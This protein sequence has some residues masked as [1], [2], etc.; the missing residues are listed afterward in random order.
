MVG[1]AGAALREDTR[2]S[3]SRGSVLQALLLLKGCAVIHSLPG[4]AA[5]GRKSALSGHM[6][7]M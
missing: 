1:H 4:G 3:L 7:R 2:A 6:H 5:K